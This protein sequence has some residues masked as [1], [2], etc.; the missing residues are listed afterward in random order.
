MSFASSDF[1]LCSGTTTVLFKS[2]SSGLNSVSLFLWFSDISVHT[3]PSVIASCEYTDTSV[4]SESFVCSDSFPVLLKSS[5]SDLV[6]VA[7]TPWSSNISVHPSLSVIASCEYTDSSV[8]SELFVCSNSSSFLFKPSSADFNSVALSLWFSDISVHP[9]PSVIA[10][11]EYTDS[12]VD[13]ELFVCS[14]SAIVLFKSSLS[15][16]DSVALTFWSS[17]TS[18]LFSPC[19]DSVVLVL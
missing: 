13:S 1:S 3:S 7:L 11:C 18:V 14:D 16:F 10:S 12:S 9:S 8:D 2:S 4:D 15:G 17:D 6:S 5:S 19:L